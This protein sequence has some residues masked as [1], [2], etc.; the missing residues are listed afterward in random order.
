MF[1]HNSSAEV[2]VGR[3]AV[4]IIPFYR[5][6]DWGTEVLVSFTLPVDSGL[7][8][9][10]ASLTQSPGLRIT[11][12]WFPKGNLGALNR[13]KRARRGATTASIV[14]IEQKFGRE[15]S[16]L[17]CLMLSPR[18]QEQE[19]IT[20]K[21]KEVLIKRSLWALG[22]KNNKTKI[23]GRLIAR[24]FCKGSGAGTEV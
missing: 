24:L 15:D 4:F 23:L 7:S 13:K 6:E 9:S 8:T 10:H 2:V 22:L 19:A 14:R 16:F 17:F 21:R 18:F 20:R 5:W 11:R 3:G 12:R 1:P